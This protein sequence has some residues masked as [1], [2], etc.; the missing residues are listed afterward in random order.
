MAP[1]WDLA[2]PQEKL[3]CLL[4]QLA[5]TELMSPETEDVSRKNNRLG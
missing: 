2:Q 5:C 3:K 4:L 1:L